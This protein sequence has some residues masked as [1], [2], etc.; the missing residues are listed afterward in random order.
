MPQQARAQELKL[1]RGE[2]HKDS[3]PT[4]QKACFVNTW[5]EF[6][7][8]CVF[9]FFVSTVKFE[10]LLKKKYIKKGN[11][12]IF[13]PHL[14]WVPCLGWWRDCC[15][16]SATQYWKE[17]FCDIKISKSISI[18]TVWGS[19]NVERLLSLSLDSI[20]HVEWKIP[21]KLG[22]YSIKLGHSSTHL[23]FGGR[24][25]TVDYLPAPH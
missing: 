12:I 21:K 14:A 13:R 5:Y 9:P 7:C 3:H 22:N 11:E 24:L 18:L 10:G 16:H 1:Q 17:Q 15:T 8:V 19:I 4:S 6:V 25:H 23:S 2:G 20:H